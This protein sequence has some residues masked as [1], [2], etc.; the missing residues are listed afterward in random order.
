MTL[1]SDQLSPHAEQ[2][3]SEID[4]MEKV[5]TT[6]TAISEYTKDQTIYKK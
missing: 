1:I 5:Q 3:Y 4:G 2:K 6:I